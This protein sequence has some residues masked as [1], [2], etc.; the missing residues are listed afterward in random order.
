MKKAI[1]PIQ[2]KHKNAKTGRFWKG[3]EI[4]EA[5]TPLRVVTIEDD[6]TGAKQKDWSECV[7]A[8]ACKRLFNSTSVAFFRSIAYVEILD[9]SGKPYVERYQMDTK[10]RD[11]IEKFDKTGKMPPGGFVLKPPRP[12]YTL[13]DKIKRNA[14]ARKKAKKHAVIKGTTLQQKRADNSYSPKAMEWR[15]GSGQVHFNSPKEPVIPAK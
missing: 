6:A 3:V 5:T 10:I 8:R 7:F 13:N 12:S 1:H 11:Q 9:E 15:M 14:K 4:K 2:T